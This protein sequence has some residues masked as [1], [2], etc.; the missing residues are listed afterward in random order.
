[1]IFRYQKFK[2]LISI[3]SSF[4]R[5]HELDYLISQIRILDFKQCFFYIEQEAHGPHRSP[6]K[7][8]QIN[9]HI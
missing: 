4:L 6:E 2:F 8:F 9:K 1:M 5:Y 3:N 7:T